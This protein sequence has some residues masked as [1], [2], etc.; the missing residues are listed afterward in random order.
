MGGL[1]RIPENKKGIATPDFRLPPSQNQFSSGN[2]NCTMSKL[3]KETDKTAVKF[4]CVYTGD[5]IG[6]IYPSRISV[7]MP[8]GNDYATAQTN[9]KPI[10][11]YKGEDAAFVAEWN[12]MQGG[13][14]MDMQKVEMLLRWNDT[15]TEN[16]VLKTEGSSVDF[17]FNEALSN[18]KGK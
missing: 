4:K 15:F 5:Q 13:A 7:K 18:E 12:R 10:L 8:D 9:P 6:I 16:A 3:S 11:L 1:Y 14:S 2:F 17:T